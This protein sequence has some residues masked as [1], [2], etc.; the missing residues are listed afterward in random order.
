MRDARIL[1]RLL[2]QTVVTQSV[3]QRV[4]GF[5]EELHSVS[6]RSHVPSFVVLALIGDLEVAAIA[7]PQR[8]EQMDD[9]DV[10]LNGTEL[11]LHKAVWRLIERSLLCIF[12]LKQRRQMTFR[13][14]Q[15][16]ERVMSRRHINHH[17]SDHARRVMIRIR[18]PDGCLAAQR[19][20]QINNA[21]FHIFNARDVIDCAAVMNCY[22]HC[23]ASSKG[24]LI[25]R[26]SIV[27]T[28]LTAITTG[29]NSTR[30]LSFVRLWLHEFPL[31]V[32][33]QPHGISV[34]PD[35]FV[36]WH[37]VDQRF[38][39]DS[40]LFAVDED[41]LVLLLVCLPSPLLRSGQLSLRFARFLLFLFRHLSVPFRMESPGDR[42]RQATAPA[43]RCGSGSRRL[44]RPGQDNVQPEN[45]DAHRADGRTQQ[46][47]WDRR[48][49][50]R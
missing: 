5:G 49:G 34:G 21:V 2:T 10:A 42:R 3:C 12:N 1:S 22:A 13:R 6:Q 35:E 43:H 30:Q 29:S 16:T 15:Q 25:D 11:R 24:D 50:S 46:R 44:A 37:P 20:R 36:D 18:P 38:A 19:K 7:L 41:P 45:Q 28:F 32:L 8:I 40:D 31:P 33:M 39:F 14:H 27:L 9:G 48:F 23:S 26:S 17:A 47:W 4:H